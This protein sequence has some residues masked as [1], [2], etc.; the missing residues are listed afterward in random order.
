MGRDCPQGTL[1]A[2]VRARVAAHPEDRAAFVVLSWD[3]PDPQAA[4]AASRR[5]RCSRVSDR[6][7]AFPRAT[8]SLTEHGWTP[9]FLPGVLTFRRRA[10]G[11]VVRMAK[12][13][14]G[15]G[16]PNAALWRLFALLEDGVG[17]GEH[18]LRYGA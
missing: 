17:P 1:W 18:H 11:V 13:A 4:S 14:F 6:T 15:P 10:D 9:L 7:R 8:G 5:W 3:P 2:D 12:A 16:D